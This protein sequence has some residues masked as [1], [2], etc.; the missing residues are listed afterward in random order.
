M[1]ERCSKSLSGD[2][3]L[4]YLS[5]AIKEECSQGDMVLQKGGYSNVSDMTIPAVVADSRQPFHLHV[6]NGHGSVAPT[7]SRLQA[8]PTDLSGPSSV[9]KENQSRKTPKREGCEQQRKASVTSRKLQQVRND[10]V[11]SNKITLGC[12]TKKQ[13]SYLKTHA[14]KQDVLFQVRTSLITFQHFVF[15]LVLI[16]WYHF[17]DDL[18][19]TGCS[20]RNRQQELQ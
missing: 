6:Q 9:I 10:I 16:Y 17:V 3:A 19:V 2:M 15:L 14:L 7:H 1:Y 12:I 4:S 5:N 13:G 20:Y 8:H 18:F 11:T